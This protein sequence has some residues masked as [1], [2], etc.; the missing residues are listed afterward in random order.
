MRRA[1]SLAALGAG[2]A[3]GG[4]LPAFAQSSDGEWKA[5]FEATAV[6]AAIEDETPLAP[7]APSMIGSATVTVTRS[8]TFENGLTVGWRGE[9]RL[10]RD[11]PS[12]PAFAGVLGGCPAADALCPRVTSGGG[13]LSPVSPSTGLAAAGS[14]LDEDGFTSIEAASVSL[15]GPWGE[16]VFGLDSGVAARLDARAPTVLRKVSAFSPGLDP[17]GL[18]VTRAR[19]DVTGSSLKAT[20][21]TPRWLGLRAGAS[22]TP[23]ADRRSADFDPDFGA[24][25]QGKAELENVWEGAVSFARQFAEQ[26]LRVRAA[27]T[28]SQADS[29]AALPAF[30]GYEAW[31]AGLELEHAGWTGG[32]R[33]L[34]SN[35]AWE[36]GNGDYE[37]WEAGLVHQIGEWRFGVEG[38]WA[39]DR[40]TGVD[41][42]S[43]LVGASRQIND[44]LDIG[45]AWTSADADIPV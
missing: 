22:Y 5:S 9:V 30:G 44:N 12:R 37:A 41:G 35:N 8:D 29:S 40:L 43:W 20:Y 13:F 7:S 2:T 27:V 18:G 42:S 11:A 23:E 10:E 25:G 28:Y 19:N 3:L 15:E 31:G 1:I 24:G 6:G 33:W 4:A 17:T 26:D 45:L 38:G 39:E 32:V 36:S 34:S 14:V 16:G 21:M